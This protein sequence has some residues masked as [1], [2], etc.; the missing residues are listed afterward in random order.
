M[1]YG[2]F[3]PHRQTVGHLSGAKLRTAPRSIRGSLKYDKNLVGGYF[4]NNGL[5]STDERA[6]VRF[7]C[8]LIEAPV[9][10]L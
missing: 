3:T 2:Q 6:P 8:L 5:R 4:S 1:S 10:G 7:G 9:D